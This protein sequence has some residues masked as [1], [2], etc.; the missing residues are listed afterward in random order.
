MCQCLVNNL[1][2]SGWTVNE[3]PHQVQ[4]PAYS[5][6]Q[7]WCPVYSLCQCWCPAAAFVTDLQSHS[8]RSWNG[9]SREIPIPVLKTG[10]HT[11]WHQ[12]FKEGTSWYREASDPLASVLLLFIY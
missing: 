12:S 11:V 7:F 9:F 5:P 2:Q 10:K 4:Y 8:C 1:H 6:C 3:G